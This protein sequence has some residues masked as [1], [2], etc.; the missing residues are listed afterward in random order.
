MKVFNLVIIFSGIFAFGLITIG[1][2]AS[3]VASG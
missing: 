3:M 2:V 1:M